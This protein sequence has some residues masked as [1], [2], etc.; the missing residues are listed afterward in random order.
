MGVAGARMNSG[1]LTGPDAARLV[2]V[3]PAAIRKWKERGLLA[4]AGLDE[5][6]RPLSDQLDVA[7]AEKQ[8][9][10]RAGRQVHT[11]A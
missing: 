2:G 8:T 1:L 6:H 7:R 3:T 11:A 4:P 10:A 5:R 9:R